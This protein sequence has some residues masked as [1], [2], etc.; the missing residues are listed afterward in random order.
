MKKDNIFDQIHLSK[1]MIFKYTQKKAHP[2]DNTIDTQYS[3]IRFKKEKQK[4]SKFYN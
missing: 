2:I 1:L 4:L 3:F